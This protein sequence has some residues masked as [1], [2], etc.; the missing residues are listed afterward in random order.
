MSPHAITV[1]LGGTVL[2]SFYQD[3]PFYTAYHVASLYP[4]QNLTKEQ[5]IFYACVI[6]QNRY[7]YNYGRQ[8]NKTLKNILVPDINEI[9]EYVYQSTISKY[10]LENQPLSDK[11]IALCTEKWKWFNISD[12][13]R[14]ERGRRLTKEN[15]ICGDIP[16]IT[17]GET[18]EGLANYIANDEMKIYH[19]AITIDMFCNCVYRDYEF[20]CD[21]NILVLTI[22]NAVSKYVKLFLSTI[23]EYDKYRYDYGRQYRLKN[24]K[25][26]KIKLPIDTKGLPD[27]QFM[28]DYIKSLPYSK[29]I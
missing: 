10:C 6:K 20:A 17:A 15:R 4:K 1:A 19:D 2:S 9:P 14:A 11:K 21:D 16:L 28:E 5:M 22:N 18:N 24:F 12:L 25:K 26:H 23:I 13:F 3:E 8:A 7:K 29:E 27:W